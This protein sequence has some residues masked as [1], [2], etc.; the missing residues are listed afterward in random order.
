MTM[1]ETMHQ[2]GDSQERKL[3]PCLMV[4]T[5]LQ[6][7][8]AFVAEYCNR[9]AMPIAG[10][11]LNVIPVAATFLATLTLCCLYTRCC[12]KPHALSYYLISIVAAMLV[13][14]SIFVL[15][16]CLIRMLPA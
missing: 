13:P 5:T 6:F 7:A 12:H 16:F 15:T 9:H 1:N 4:F 8:L 10:Y 2:S 3:G 11:Y 14:V